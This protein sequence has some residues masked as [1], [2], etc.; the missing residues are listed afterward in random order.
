MAAAGRERVRRAGSW[1]SCPFH[2][3]AFFS[4]QE[5]EEGV[6]LPFMAEG[7]ASGEKCI[8]ILDEER[9]AEKLKK[10]GEAGID[11]A[12]AERSGQLELRPWERAHAAGG[13]FNKDAMLDGLERAALSEDGTFP[14]TRLWSNQEWALEGHSW[15]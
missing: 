6:Y 13:Q 8:H 15:P 11:L 10:L 14:L 4:C 5:E 12:T 3:C 2:A 7:I 1:L 9:R